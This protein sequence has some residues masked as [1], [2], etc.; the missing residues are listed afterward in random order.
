MLCPVPG[1]VFGSK[2]N[3]HGLAIFLDTYPNDEATEVSGSGSSFSTDEAVSSR[4]RAPSASCPDHGKVS[5]YV[6]VRC[7]SRPGSWEREEF[8]CALTEMRRS[9][10][11]LLLLLTDT[12]VSKAFPHLHER[13]PQSCSWLNSALYK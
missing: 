5:P 9:L 12:D 8:E 13:V 6:R 11:C 10:F 4:L 7:S 2:D 3:F 1:P